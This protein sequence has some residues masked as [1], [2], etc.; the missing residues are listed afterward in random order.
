MAL[1]LSEDEVSL[2]SN[3]DLFEFN[4]NNSLFEKLKY[5]IRHWNQTLFFDGIFLM[6][7]S[8]VVYVAYEGDIS[9]TELLLR[10]FFVDFKVY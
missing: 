4:A 5:G 1:K 6:I 2:H 8:E 9:N 10:R 7:R 3:F